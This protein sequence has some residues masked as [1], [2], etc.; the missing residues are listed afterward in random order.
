MEID[1]AL[2]GDVFSGGKGNMSQRATND[3]TNVGPIAKLEIPN[4]WSR[5]VDNQTG[6]GHRMHMEFTPPGKEDTHVSVL[7]PGFPLNRNA[8][9]NLDRLLAD[10]QNL[11]TPRALTPEQIRSLS[12]VLGNTTV[13]DNQYSNQEHGERSPVFRMDSARLMNVD[14]QTVIAVDGAF[15]D[16]AGRTKN[17]FSGVFVPHR[18]SHGTEI[19]SVSLESKNPVDFA[20]TKT[21]F[22]NVVRTLD[23]K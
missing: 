23:L 9:D 20:M 8:A 10:N 11:S 17:Q 21:T 12:D 7:Y 4:N 16:S 15:V 6:I 22:N 14:G 18:G 5:F 2:I 19:Y 3:V 13:G 1:H